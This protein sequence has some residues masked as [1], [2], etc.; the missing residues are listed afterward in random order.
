MSTA[1]RTL[2]LKTQA[3]R[4]EAYQFGAHVAVWHRGLSW[5]VIGYRWT[6]NELHIA[7]RFPRLGKVTKWIKQSTAK[8]IA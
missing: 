2:K 3:P 8:G 7:H 6:D 5:V 4:T 1:L